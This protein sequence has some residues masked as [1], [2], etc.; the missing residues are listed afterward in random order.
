MTRNPV[1]GTPIFLDIRYFCAN[2]YLLIE[3]GKDGVRSSAA[4]F[5]FPNRPQSGFKDLAVCHRRVRTGPLPP[6]KFCKTK[7]SEAGMSFIINETSEK[8]AKNEAN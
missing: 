8:R 6:M 5:L 3:A 4:C 1:P 2:I 7:P